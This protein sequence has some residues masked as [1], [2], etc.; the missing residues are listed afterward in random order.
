LKSLYSV[1]WLCD[2]DTHLDHCHVIGQA[3]RSVSTYYITPRPT[4]P[5]TSS[6]YLR[7]LCAVPF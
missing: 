5:S 7:M 6:L 2:S 4:K 3:D 1:C